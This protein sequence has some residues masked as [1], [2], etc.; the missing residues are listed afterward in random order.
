MK[1]SK[2]HKNG[3]LQWR[4]SFQDEGRQRRSFFKTRADADRFVDG[5]ADKADPAFERWARLPERLRF[6][7]LAAA[8]RAAAENYSL[9][10]A[11]A[12]FESKG[13][14]VSRKVGEAWGDY[15]ALKE[16]QQ[17]LS[18]AALRNAAMAWRFLENYQAEQIADIGAAHITEWM[19]QH[20]WAPASRNSF[21]T[22]LNVFLN[23]CKKRGYVSGL[24][25][26]SIPRAIVGE[27]PVGILDVKAARALMRACEKTD[28]GLIPY[29]ALSLFC[30][31]RPSECLRVNW[32]QID[33]RRRHIDVAAA[34]ARKTRKARFVHLTS[35]AVAWLKLGGDLPLKN[36][37]RRWDRVRAAAKLVRIVEVPREKRYLVHPLNWPP[38]CLRHSFAS[39]FTPLHSIKE[40]ATEC[41]NS[42][43]VQIKH[44]RLPLTK[45]EC[46]RYF[47]I[48]PAA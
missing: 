18:K 35:N 40:A 9:I 48:M 22:Q 32:S 44:Y 31:L 21:L 42:E 38:D 10:E 47:A 41:G 33:L 46:R 11:A 3:R 6:E 1:I 30:G 19:G 7:A 34:V 29:A 27:H 26:E 5:M 25:T 36:F 12:F 24:A 15:I 43:Q 13:G 20:S 37:R 4:V 14:R 39:H 17:G 2:V 8:E 16:K 28:R 45:A 23:W